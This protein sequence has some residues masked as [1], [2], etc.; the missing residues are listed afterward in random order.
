MTSPDSA[1]SSASS[2][3][4]RTNA[5][6]TEKDL[7]FRSTSVA[8]SSPPMQSPM[9]SPSSDVDLWTT[10][11]SPVPGH[12][13]LRSHDPSSDRLS[14]RST[15]RAIGGGRSQ[16]GGRRSQGELT[17]RSG[18]D[19][20]GS[21]VVPSGLAS[22][23]ELVGAYSNH[24]GT[25]AKFADLRKRITRLSRHEGR[26]GAIDGKE[27]LEGSTWRKSRISFRG[28]GLD[29]PSTSWLSSSGFTARR[30]SV[31]WSEK[32]FKEG[33]GRFQLLRS[34]RPPSSVRAGGHSL[35]WVQSWAVMRARF[36]GRWPSWVRRHPRNE[37][38]TFREADAAN[39]M[40]FASMTTHALHERHWMLDRVLQ[41]LPAE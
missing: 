13:A 15:G 31:F 19:Q 30:V 34:R 41:E 27:S 28:T 38:G 6:L 25:A 32:E 17:T 4:D 1:I 11:M 24:S 5:H 12:S 39:A 18:F 22:S 2:A 21:R 16:G 10:M 3:S 23:V 8:T 9:Q 37:P 26:P 29:S 20:R 40:I 7:T 14:R 33:E 36:V 35:R